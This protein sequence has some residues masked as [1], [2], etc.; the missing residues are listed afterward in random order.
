MLVFTSKNKDTTITA[1]AKNMN[2]GIRLSMYVGGS[3]K[4]KRK[5]AKIYVFD[6][7]GMIGTVVKHLKS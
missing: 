6:D 3:I 1:S 7:T 2:A 4:T 5:G